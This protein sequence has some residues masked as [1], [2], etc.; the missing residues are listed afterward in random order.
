[1]TLQKTGRPFAVVALAALSTGCASTGDHNGPDEL[2]ATRM[3]CGQATIDLDYAPSTGLLTLTHGGKR[4]LMAPR[5]SASGARFV[6]SGDDSTVFWSKGERASLSLNGESF[7][8]CLVAGALES[9]FVARGN[10]PFWH[11]TLVNNELTLSRMG[12]ATE[13]LFSRAIER[14]DTGQTIRAERE[15]LKIR[16]AVAPQLCQDSMSGMPYPNQVRLSVNGEEQAGCGGDPERLLRGAEWVVED[17]GG[18]GLIDSSRVTIQFLDDERVVGRGS[19]N[20]YMGAW[21]L[22]GEGLAFDRMASTQ[23]ACA[24]ALMDQ[25]QRFLALMAEVNRFRI[26]QHGELILSTNNGETLRAFQSSDKP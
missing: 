3:H 10:E 7:P 15:G 9:P 6:A 18:D 1:M 11:V 25:E 14:S 23:M 5:E 13:T 8:E 2:S 4:Y 19:C 20:R 21:D 22:T 17:I 16:L 26:G 12:E 24:P